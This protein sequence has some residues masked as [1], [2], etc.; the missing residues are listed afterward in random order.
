[1]SIFFMQIADSF[2]H[3]WISRND[4]SALFIELISPR[5]LPRSRHNYT[6]ICADKK[7][8]II[9]KHIN[10]QRQKVATIAHSETPPLDFE[11][12]PLG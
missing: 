10:L 8:N 1:M 11:A 5:S 6:Q 9:I 7:R 12:P 2:A 4:F 3:L